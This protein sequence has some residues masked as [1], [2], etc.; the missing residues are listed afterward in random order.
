M[1]NVGVEK[2]FFALRAGEEQKAKEQEGN[3]GKVILQYHKAKGL[4]ESSGGAGKAEA[5][6]A[7]PIAGT[8]VD[9][10][11][12]PTEPRNVEPGTPA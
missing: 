10:D 6:V 11:R 5:V 1:E 3:K 2:N 7:V 4:R 12:R 8:A 9:A